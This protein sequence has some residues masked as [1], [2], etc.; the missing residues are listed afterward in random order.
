MTGGDVMTARFMRAEFF[1]F[2]PTFKVFLATN[3]KPAI[4]GTDHAMWRRVRLVPFTVTIPPEEQDRQL[5]VKLRAEWPGILRWA[6]EGCLAWQRDGLDVPEEVRKA[7]DAYRA[8]M[9]VLGQFLAERCVLAADASVPSADLYATY[10]T[11]CEEAKDRPMPKRTFGL[12]LA[13]R[14]L[15]PSRTENTRGW[16]GARLRTPSDPTPAP[17]APDA[18]GWLTHPET[19]S[20]FAEVRARVAQPSGKLRQEASAGVDASERD[21]VEL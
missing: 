13:E 14:G 19:S 1:D 21:E 15:V 2:V 3:Y 10:T 17:G 12:R 8:D 16:R 7:T 11:W 20:R 4:R 9:D 18:M 6:V 5:E